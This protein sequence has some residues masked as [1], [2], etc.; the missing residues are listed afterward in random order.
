[1]LSSRLELSGNELAVKAP[2]WR[3]DIEIKEDLVEEVGRL[4]G[5][6]N[7]PHELPKRNIRPVNKDRMLIVK[8]SVREILVK[9]GANE[10]LTYSF[11][12]GNL[13]SKVGW[14]SDNLFQLSN[15]LSPDL[16]Y[17]R[18]S[19]IPSLLDKVHANIKGGYDEFVLFE[20]GKVHSSAL[21]DQN[22]GL[23]VDND[24]VTVVVAASDKLKE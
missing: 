9:S 19:L 3:T 4:Y 14:S 1:M 15:A 24:V 23:P 12:H 20:I 10:V 8:D 18:S 21:I 11:V 17:Y 16:Q 13:Y 6:D 7:L 5:Y 2:F 22:S